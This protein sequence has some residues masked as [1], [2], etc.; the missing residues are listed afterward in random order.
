MRSLRRFSAVI[1]LVL[2]GA[3]AGLAQPAA[4]SPLQLLRDVDALPHADRFARSEEAVVSYEIGLGPI[5]KHFGDWQ[6]KDSVRVDGERNR[7]GWQIVDGYSAATVYR[8]LVDSA[9]DWPDSELLFRC[10]GRGCGNAA[11]WAN[12]VFGERV[13]YGRADAQRYSVYRMSGEEGLWYLLAYA[14]SRT[15]DRQYL[16]AE[17]VSVEGGGGEAMPSD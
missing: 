7:Y 3:R 16:H 2:L 1:A 5:E 11:Q 15:A 9:G 12:G 17:V 4:E 13:L 8:D 10:E 14:A 6:F